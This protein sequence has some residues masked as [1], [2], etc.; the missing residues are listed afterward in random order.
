MNGRFLTVLFL[1]LPVAAQNN[2]RVPR[3]PPDMIANDSPIRDVAK[4]DPKHVRVDS[5]NAR[6]RVLRISLPAGEALPMHDARDGVLVCLTACVLT[7]T[8]PVGYVREIKLD[9][10]R[11]A[12]MGAARNRVANTGGAAEML[13]IE[14]KQ[15][16]PLNH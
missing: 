11:T 8:N 6:L 14:A 7:L 15:Q 9:A 3:F 12:W 1:A 4:L 5:D 10:G 16:I 13:Y 2:F